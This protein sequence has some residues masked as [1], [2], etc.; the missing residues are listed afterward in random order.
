HEDETSLLR[1]KYEIGVVRGGLIIVDDDVGPAVAAE[2]VP[3]D[4]KR[5]RFTTH[6]AAQ[7]HE[8]TDDVAS[9]LGAALI[10]LLRRDRSFHR[11][12]PLCRSGYG[13]RP[14]GDGRRPGRQR[15][16]TAA[17]QDTCAPI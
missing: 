11:R 3:A 12:R 2:N 13:V 5:V 1:A 8:P 6:D 15:D 16:P 9:W 17:A 10:D 4:P 7:A 14:S